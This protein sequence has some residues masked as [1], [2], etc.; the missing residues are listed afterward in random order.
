MNITDKELKV[1]YGVRGG[2]LYTPS[3][4]LRGLACDCTCPACGSTLIANHGGHKRPYFSHSHTYEC[5]TGLET[6]I[7]K[8]AKQI[9][10]GQKKIFTPEFND[11]IENK[12][13]TG[14]VITETVKVHGQLVQFESVLEERSLEGFVPDLIG[15]TKDGGEYLIEIF[16]THSVSDDK[17]RRLSNRNLIEIDLSALRDIDFNKIDEVS[18]QV[19]YLAKRQW[20]SCNLYKTQV[21][22][23]GVRLEH[24]IRE[25]NELKI[26][27]R[28]SLINAIGCDHQ[29]NNRRS[30]ILAKLEH[31]FIENGRVDVMVCNIC[32]SFQSPYRGIK[33]IAC[34]SESLV[35]RLL[36]DD[37]VK[38]D[39]C[40][41][42][43][44]HKKS[45]AVRL[46]DL[47]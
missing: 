28:E 8:M 47:L 36:S 4:T 27:K 22:E 40:A 41:S 23:A 46:K 30:C 3:E 24:R 21:K 34:C 45:S 38:T 31:D 44:C 26:N 16:V 29:I 14:D 2:R 11:I 33:C 42:C 6:A 17:Q 32:N 18:E 7:H 1:P 25:F 15:F 9:I 13:P 20:L 37:K 5:D 19:I 10:M 35:Y 39:L 43:G 12:L